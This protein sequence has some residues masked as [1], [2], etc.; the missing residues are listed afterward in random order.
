MRGPRPKWAQLLPMYL[1]PLGYRSYHSGKWH[2]DGRPLQNGFDRSYQ[3]ADHGRFFSPRRHYKN[4][5]PLPAVERDSGYYATTFIADHAIECLK[6]HAGNYADQPFFHF[7]TFTAPHFPLH[8]LPQDIKKYKDTYDVGWD[9]MRKRR[10]E[11]IK[12]MGLIDAKIS[13]VEKD[14][15]PPYHFAKA[16]KTLG[17]G[18][19]NRPVKWDQLTDEQKK[20]QATKMA[21]HAAMVDRMDL[22][23]GRIIDQIRAMDQFENT[24]IFFLSDNGASAEIMVRDDG[25]DPNAE[26]GSAASHLCLGPGWST[27]S[28]TP[29][30]RHKTWVHEGGIATPLIVHWPQGISDKDALRTAVGHVIDIV[31]TVLQVAG[32]EKFADF[33]SNGGPP[34]PGKSLIPTFKADVGI[35]RELLWWF[36]DGHRAVSDGRWK[37]VS[38]KTEKWELFDLTVDR[39]ETDDLSEKYPDKLQALTR[40]WKTILEQ[41]R[42][43]RK[44]DTNRPK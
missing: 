36:H 21:I 31:P 22:E 13:E 15:G 16:M 35:E 41:C 38:G 17:A 29:F 10:W 39:C 30:R 6:E 34:A 5:K 8:A 40:Q 44:Q 33:Q 43:L 4:D 25:H 37:A 27:V 14:L 20:F 9:E 32:H 7:V 19:V 42:Q 24:L 11:R 18:E 2:I 26:P 3:L 1:K 28:N 23:I 12:S